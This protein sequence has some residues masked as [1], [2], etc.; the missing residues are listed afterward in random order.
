VTA[1][2]TAILLACLLFASALMPAPAW[3]QYAEGL[4]PGLVAAEVAN[5]PIDAVNSPAT[6][7]PTP[8]FT[9]RINTGQTAL[10]LALAD[11]AI[12]RFTLEVDERG[13]F[14]GQP[15]EPLQPGQYAL[16]IFDALV[17]TFIVTEAAAEGTP[18]PRAGGG[19]GGVIDVARAVPEPADFGGAIPGLALLEGRFTSLEEEARRIAA[20]EGDASR[21]AVAVVR[22]DLEAGGWQQRYESRLAVPDPADPARFALQ[23][24]SFAVAYD[25]AAQASAAF[26]SSAGAADA[27][28]STPIGQ[29][30]E[31][32]ALTGTTPDTG[33][34]YQALRLLYVQDRILG[35]IVVADLLG[36]AVDQATLEAV[37]QTVAVRAAAVSA[38]ELRGVATRAVTVDPPAG[39]DYSQDD[40]YQAV[41]GALVPLYGEDERGFV[42]REATFAGTFEA[43]VGETIGIA[44]AVGATDPVGERA[45]D[46]VVSI[47]TFPTPEDAS[48]WIANLPTLI[49]NDPLR[50]YL[51]FDPVS[52]APTVGDESAV[53]ALQRDA[54][55]VLSGFRAYIRVGTDVAIVEFSAAP[56]ATLDETLLVAEA[57]ASCLYGERCAAVTIPGFER[58]ERARAVDDAAPAS[59]AATTEAGDGPQGGVRDVGADEP[60]EPAEPAPAESPPV[61][62]GAIDPPA[63]EPTEP[64]GIIDNAP[65]PNPT[66][67]PAGPTGGVRDVTPSPDGD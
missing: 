66:P 30:S 9:G 40:A 12:V 45:F 3:A 34:T 58:E 7:D 15:P 65:A 18:R 25:D 13:R 37:A 42:A 16:Y 52:A 55:P 8:Q 33:A 26:A 54:E 59:P 60:T 51:A 44:R 63:A 38:G 56:A 36:G 29:G 27:L 24:S 20:E 53:Y 61:S 67:T 43:F 1:A 22:A 39:S 47:L 21:E 48:A 10:E 50:G 14:R 19:D 4:P 35:L 28:P 46:H 41:D 31:L 64:P 62:D 5:Q 32:V 17:G 11:G 49:A 6:D 23:V 57:Q 2:R